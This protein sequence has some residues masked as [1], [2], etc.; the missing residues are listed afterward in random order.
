[1]L[2]VCTLSLCVTFVH[3]SVCCYIMNIVTTYPWYIRSL[4]FFGLST[5]PPTDDGGAEIT[6]YFVELDDGQ[7]V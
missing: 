3:V 7:G 1:M 5:E 4:S 2:D 6:K